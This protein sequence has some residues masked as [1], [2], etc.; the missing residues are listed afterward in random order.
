MARKSDMVRLFS[1]SADL[2]AYLERLGHALANRGAND[3]AETIRRALRFAVGM[4][5]EFLGESRDALR[6]VSQA[7]SNP[8][9]QLERQ[10]LAKALAELESVFNRR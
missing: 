3:L 5:T 7:K 8:L 9:D 10:R 6:V 2:Y 4:S 1:S